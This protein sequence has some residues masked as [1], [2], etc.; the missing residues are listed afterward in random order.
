MTNE[1]WKTRWNDYYSTAVF[2]PAGYADWL[3]PHL[4][5]ICLSAPIIEFGCGFGYLS[6]LLFTRGYNILATDFAP[7]ALRALCE[8]APGIATRAIDMQL[9]LPF[10]DESFEVAVAD[11]CFHYFDS[12]TTESILAETRRIL[13]PQGLLCARVNSSRDFH[14]G[15]GV[16]LEVEP[17]LFEVNGRCKRFF[18]ESMIG[19]FF[20][21][22]SIISLKNYHTL[23]YEKPKNVFEIICV[24]VSRRLHRVR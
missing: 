2:D 3:T 6:E 14:F 10:P 11:L 5:R 1:N 24:P 21:D 17:G 16:G 18:D 7:A 22:W 23:Q 15:A 19:K 12:R 20:H 4:A 13:R 8:R 9:P